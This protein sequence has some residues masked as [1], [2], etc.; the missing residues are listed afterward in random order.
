MV[1][2]YILVGCPCYFGDQFNKYHSQYFDFQVGYSIV[3][4][5]LGDCKHVEVV[6]GNGVLYLNKVFSILERAYTEVC[7][8]DVVVLAA[9]ASAF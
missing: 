7:D 8:F 3:Q 1:L 2:N 9:Q 6:G 5:R 4:P